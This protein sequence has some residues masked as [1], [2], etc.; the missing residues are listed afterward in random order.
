MIIFI[1]I[2]YETDPPL[3]NWTW[4]SDIFLSHI[5]CCFEP[6]VSGIIWVVDY[7]RMD[8]LLCISIVLFTVVLSYA[9]ILAATLYPGSLEGG[10][11]K[12]PGYEVVLAEPCEF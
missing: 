3:F 4:N 11:G 8:L 6:Y 2:H 1:F 7:S 9:I 10:S 12:D 5:P